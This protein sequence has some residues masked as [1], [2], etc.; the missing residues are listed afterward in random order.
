[1]LHS[2]LCKKFPK[3][4]FILRSDSNFWRLLEV[5][6]LSP[7]FSTV[8]LKRVLD[9]KVHK[10]T[11]K[12]EPKFQCPLKEIGKLSVT[13]YGYKCLYKINRTE[14]QLSQILHPYVTSL[15]TWFT[16]TWTSYLIPPK[17][18]VL[19]FNLISFRW[20]HAHFLWTS[21]WISSHW[22]HT[23]AWVFTWAHMDKVAD[24][25]STEINKGRFILS[26]TG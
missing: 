4:L 7:D 15:Q 22:F 18:G 2:I 5:V 26:I 21:T 24:K 17:E 20:E 14:I 13:H 25:L 1:M 16:W 8:P 11:K 9:V 10:W 19:I 3:T 12:N 23:C 6:S